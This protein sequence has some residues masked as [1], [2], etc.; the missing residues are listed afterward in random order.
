MS[1]TLTWKIPVNDC[2]Y[3]YVYIYRSTSQIGNYTD[4]ANQSIDDNTYCDTSGSSTNWYK[5]RFFKT[6][7]SLWSDYSAPMQGGTYAGY[8]SVS[9]IREMNN[10]TTDDISD[11][12]LY[13][14]IQKATAYLNAE[15]NQRILRERILAIDSVRLNKINGSNDTYYVEKYKYHLGDMDND[16][17]VTIDDL[18]VY[19]IDSSNVET[20]LIV[21]SITPDEGKFVLRTAP[22]GGAKL[23]VTYEWTYVSEYIPHALVKLACEYLTTAFAFEKI[24]RGMSPQQVYGNVR[25]YRD[26]AAGNEFH[27]RYREV[28]TQ[29]N[30]EMVEWKQADYTF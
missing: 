8:A 24:E 14:L 13:H 20:Q 19:Q 27:K 5:I 15:I 26:M 29:I 6:I 3:D 4:L 21:D 10:L 28:V 30:S 12:D 17:K 25:I 1:T 16:G 22:T 2:S 18:I 9:E 7:G 11:T 23:Y